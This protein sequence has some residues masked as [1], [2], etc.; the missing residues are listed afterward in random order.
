MK[1]NKF[2]GLGLLVMLS[3]LVVPLAS[4]GLTSTLNVPV[5][6]GNYT[7]SITWNVTTL[8]ENTKNVTCYYNVTGG[9]IS[10]SNIL[11][12]LVANT[13]ANQ[14][15]FT[16]TVDISGYTDAATYNVTC[17][18]RNDSGNVNNISTGDT[19]TITFD[20][21]DPVPTLFVDLSGA[22][23]SYGRGLDY[24]C[25][26]AD[27]IDSSPTETFAVTHP[28]GD[29]PASTSLTL[30]S[31]TLAFLDTDYQGDYV[32]TCTSTDYTG[33]VGTSSA[34]VTVD[35]LGRINKISSTTKG[36]DIGNKWIW[37]VL[38][39]LGIYLIAKKK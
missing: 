36:F 17:W 25:T 27:G 29:S 32:F 23:Q 24:S 37:L 2:L 22:S 30:Q 33:N 5:T 11:G 38:I 15:T 19:I 14:T 18:T 20:S 16:G 21:T 9:P 39:G 31:T 28:T 7:S 35:S 13:S 8:M 6:R 3:L 1:I 34:T 26:T 12:V 10:E 4:A